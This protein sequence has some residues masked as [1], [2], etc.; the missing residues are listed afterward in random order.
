MMY[1]RQAEDALKKALDEFNQ[2]FEKDVAEFQRKVKEMDFKIFP[3]VEKL[4]M[5]W[6]KKK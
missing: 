4:D 3:A 5:N 1:L 2:L 6:K